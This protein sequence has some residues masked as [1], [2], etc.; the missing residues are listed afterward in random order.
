MPREPLKVARTTALTIANAMLFQQVLSRY[1]RSV[2]SLPSLMEGDNVAERLA[3]AW[4]RIQVEIDYIPIFQLARRL[5][6]ELTGIPGVDDALRA[7]A[8]AAQRI[9]ARQAALRHD[10]MGRIFHLLLT[11]AK[12][13]GAFYTTVPAATLLLKL[14]L[15]PTVVKIDWRDVEAI[16]R[17][18]IADLASGTGT[19]LK[20]ALHTVVDN[21]VRAAAE[22]GESPKL[23][24]V[25]RALVESVL[26]GLDVVPFA[27]HL[28]ATAL[29]LHDPE[30]RFDR[31]N[32]VTLPL[33]APLTRRR[34]V[35]PQARSRIR[36]GSIEVFHDRR[37][38]IQAD[39]F[40]AATGPTRRTTRTTEQI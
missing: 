22:A 33:G 15:D 1:N 40:G 6:I 36:L 39:L 37:I 18:R 31:M 24:K 23:A 2:P 7:L 13:F 29:A 28:A 9:T 11:D 21:H 8:Q 34:R 4:E 17:L 27:I 19:L 26:W 5:V 38:A 12:Y 20:A 30:V 14:A 35:A 32:L 10:L 3:E 16:N 25:H